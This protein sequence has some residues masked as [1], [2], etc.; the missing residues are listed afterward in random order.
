MKKTKLLKTIILAIGCFLVSHN[1]YSQIINYTIPFAQQQP[2]WLMPLWFEDAVGQK[3]TM[4]FS[5]QPGIINDSFHWSQYGMYPKHVDTSKMQIGWGGSWWLLPDSIQYKAIVVDRVSTNS[6]LDGFG[7]SM[8][9]VALPLIMRWDAKCFYS[10]SL[11][12]FP[13]LD[14]APRAQGH[15]VYDM[16]TYIDNCSFQ[17]AIV[18]TDTLAF[19]PLACAKKDSITFRQGLSFMG[20]LL[21]PWV[22]HSIDVGVE[23]F[24]SLNR[25]NSNFIYP[26]PVSETINLKMEC[27]ENTKFEILNMLGEVIKKGNIHQNQISIEELKNGMYVLKIYN[28]KKILINQ[29][30]KN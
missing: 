7:F 24:T 10:D 6:E 1:S 15:F 12:C 30:I 8:K 13:D 21:L 17:Y 4:Y 22:G 16:P 5:Y 2:K 18:M 23:D 26:N 25:N 27:K 3:D 9:H 19:G 14:P 11:S 28:E 29:F 20:F